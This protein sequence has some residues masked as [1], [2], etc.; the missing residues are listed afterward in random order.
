MAVNPISLT[1]SGKNMCKLYTL[2]LLGAV[3]C[4]GCTPKPTNQD[5]STGVHYDFIRA[6]EAAGTPFGDNNYS[7][8]S[9]ANSTGTSYRCNMI[10]EDSPLQYDF[11]TGFGLETA[12]MEMC[13]FN[14]FG[15]P[16]VVV[17]YYKGTQSG[18]RSLQN[19][20]F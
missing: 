6:Q 13:F 12:I 3:F 19:V 14:K 20:N 10:A 5:L 7:P 8:E 9:L 16:E 17:V 2:F 4:L 15:H 1:F 18:Y 11:N